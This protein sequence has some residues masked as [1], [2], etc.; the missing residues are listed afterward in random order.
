MKEV[1]LQSV[2]AKENTALEI[3]RIYDEGATGKT[4]T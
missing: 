4:N 1:L 2:T 3:I